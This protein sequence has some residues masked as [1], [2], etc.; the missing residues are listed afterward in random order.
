MLHK[1]HI[2]AV[3]WVVIVGGHA[4]YHRDWSD[5]TTSF[6]FSVLLS[7]SDLVDIEKIFIIN[8][9]ILSA[10]EILPGLGT[11]RGSFRILR[12]S[13]E[14]K[15]EQPPVMRVIPKIE[16]WEQSQSRQNLY[17]NF[18]WKKK[19]LLSIFYPVAG[20]DV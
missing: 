1:L 17:E 15:P 4:N 18:Q 3:W 12:A 5:W 11:V 14:S 19:T 10:W 2:K 6:Y 9:L 8:Y 20:F 13:W 7:L 16:Q